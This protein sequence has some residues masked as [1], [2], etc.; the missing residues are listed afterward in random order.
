MYRILWLILAPAFL[1]MTFVVVGI[2]RFT[3]LSTK[4]RLVWV[5][6]GGWTVVVF[7]AALRAYLFNSEPRYKVDRLKRD[8]KPAWIAG[9]ILF[10]LIMAGLSC[11]IAL[12]LIQAAAQYLPGK[13]REMS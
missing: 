4:P 8:R 2:D 3:T 7:Y 5:L 13:R 1:W 9:G 12:R 11:F 6:V 10:G